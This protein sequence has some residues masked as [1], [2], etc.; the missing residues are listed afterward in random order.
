MMAIKKTNWRSLYTIAAAQEQAEDIFTDEEDTADDL[1]PPA[2][3]PQVAAFEPRYEEEIE[4]E[5]EAYVARSDTYI[6][7]D[8]SIND[9]IDALRLSATRSLLERRDVIIVAYVHRYQERWF[10]A[11]VRFFKALFDSHAIFLPRV[12]FAVR[13]VGKAAT[14]ALG[15]Y[16]LRNGPSDRPIIGHTQNQTLFTVE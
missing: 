10:S 6:E 5:P 4:A 8:L 12:I 9:R 11:R 14:A 2:Y 16:R 1:P 15:H 13:Q 3:Q 7:K